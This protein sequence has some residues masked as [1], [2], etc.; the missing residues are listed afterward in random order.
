[1]NLLTDEQVKMLAIAISEISR[2]GQT[3]PLGLESVAMALGGEGDPGVAN[4]TSGLEQ[5]ADAIK[6]GLE[7]H[8]AAMIEVAHALKDVSS[9]IGSIA[10]APGLN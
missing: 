7:E 10:S 6:N 2:G 1:M 5:I 4:V 8:S 9:A 3:G